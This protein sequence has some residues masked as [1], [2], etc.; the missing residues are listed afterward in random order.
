MSDPLEKSSEDSG[1]VD[2]IKNFLG[3]GGST[4]QGESLGTEDLV[5]ESIKEEGSMVSDPLG[6]ITEGEDLIGKVRNF[7]AGFVGY[8]DRENRRE[9]DKILR[10]TI[11]QRYEEQWGRI[12]EL[13]RQLVS[14]GQLELVDDL[15]AATIKLRAF[16]DRVKGASYG[17]AGFFDAV[18]IHSDELAKV[19]QYD[20]A[21]L[22]GAQNIAN[23]VDNVAASIG[24]DGL[25]AAIRNLTSLSQE[26]IDAY[27]RRDE[28]IL[29]TGS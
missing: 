18:R 28:V 15:E 19:Y 9:A 1:I 14:E 16:V 25:P 6:K 10:E 11:A 26:A 21:L 23:A 20:I 29:T 24:S 17:Y 8:V 2:K 22:E 27:N 13:Q 3:F 5:Q 4:G 12:S 7:L